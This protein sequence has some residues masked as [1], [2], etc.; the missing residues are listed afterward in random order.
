MCKAGWNL[1]FSFSSTG[2]LTK[3]KEYRLPYD[4]RIA[5]VRRTDGFIPFSTALVQ[6]EIQTASFWI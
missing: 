6:S 3:A 4:L 1:E 5:E 2:C